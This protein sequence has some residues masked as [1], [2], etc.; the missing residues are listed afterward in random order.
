MGFLAQLTAISRRHDS[1][2]NVGA[3]FRAR[4]S[5]LDA[6]GDGFRRNRFAV[7]CAHTQGAPC[8]DAAD[9]DRH[10]KLAIRARCCMCHTAGALR[11]L[12]DDSC[13]GHGPTIAV[14]DC[15]CNPKWRITGAQERAREKDSLPRVLH[16]CHGRGVG[17]YGP[18]SNGFPKSYVPVVSHEYA[19]AAMCAGKYTG[20]STSCCLT[21]CSSWFRHIAPGARARCLSRPSPAWKPIC[22]GCRRESPL[23]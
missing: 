15:P 13:P 3:A 4:Q 22:L 16:C 21:C 10:Y 9:V 23:W 2:F 12:I 18:V 7:W 6:A 17:L 5:L 11:T 19:W 14:D 1:S 20:P 8:V